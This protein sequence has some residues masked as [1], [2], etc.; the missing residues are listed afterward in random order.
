MMIKYIFEKIR[1]KNFFG[2]KNG[3][4]SIYDIVQICYI[5]YIMRSNI[6]LLHFRRA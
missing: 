6:F 3:F 2:F 1:E 4:F 5:I